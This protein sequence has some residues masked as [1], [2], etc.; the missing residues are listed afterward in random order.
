MEFIRLGDLKE[1]ERD[2]SQYWKLSGDQ[3]TNQRLLSSKS[4]R[5][6]SPYD[7]KDSSSFS[8]MLQKRSEAAHSHK[9]FW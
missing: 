3:G 1:E 5:S 4:L 7:R 2:L 6:V 8:V 9:S